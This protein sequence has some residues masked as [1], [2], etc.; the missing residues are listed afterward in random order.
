MDS[1]LPGS[2]V[3]GTVAAPFSSAL[4]L[5]P[6]EPGVY[7]AELPKAWTVG[8]HKVHGGLLLALLTK[9]GLAGLDAYTGAPEVSVATAEPVAV[10]AE[11]LRAPELGP[12]ELATEV[13]K[14]GRTASV[15]RV[16]LG[17]DG[18]AAITGTV[19]AG[20]LPDGPEFWA[21]LPELPAEPPPG[22]LLTSDAPGRVAPLAY[23]CDVVL[24]RDTAAFAR[25]ETGD[26]VLRGWV[27]PVGEPPDVFF[28]LMAGD[29]L[30]PLLFNLGRPGWTPTVQLT[31]LVRGRPA[32]GWLRLE[33]SARVVRGDWF[34][35]D[36]TIID[37]EGRLICQARQLALAPKRR[38]RA[39][40]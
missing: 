19:T 13:V 23:A 6:V 12:V 32:P 26:P 5:T 35:E 10:S 34:D 24:D 25:G 17:Q 18:R 20:R 22:A 3:A 2:T 40:G 7:R 8:R 21:D 4:E 14:V 27:R 30:P 15:V 38:D 11:F 29:I 9:A 39:G 37:A 28:A 1:R 16:S 36:C 33:A 31:A